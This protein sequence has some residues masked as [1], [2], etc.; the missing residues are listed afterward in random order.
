MAATIPTITAANIDDFNRQVDGMDALRKVGDVLVVN[1]YNSATGET[2]RSRITRT[3][4]RGVVTAC[5]EECAGIFAQLIASITES[6]PKKKDEVKCRAFK[7]AIEKTAQEIAGKEI[8]DLEEIVKLFKG[9][10]KQHSEEELRKIINSVG[11]E[12]ANS[13]ITSSHSQNRSVETKQ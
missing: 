8:D 7:V 12:A 9:Y 3:D 11:I 10:I 4:E 1:W 5:C 6:C 13:Y 2:T